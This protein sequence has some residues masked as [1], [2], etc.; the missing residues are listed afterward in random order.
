MLLTY[1]LHNATML[2]RKRG[3]GIDIRVRLKED[4]LKRIDAKGCGCCIRIAQPT[5]NQKINNTR[6]MD[7]DEAEKLAA[8]LCIK[9]EEFQVYFFI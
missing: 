3:D 1:L 8:L 4:L 2:E 6:P 7:L 5:A 9:P